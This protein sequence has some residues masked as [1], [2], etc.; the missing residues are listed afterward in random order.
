[1]KTPFSIVVAVDA[2]FGIGRGGLLPWH[3]PG[4]MKHFKEV[5]LEGSSEAHRNVVIMGRKTWDSIPDKFRPLPGRRNIVLTR[6][7]TPT[8]PSGVERAFDFEDALLKAAQSV[9]SKIFVIGGGEIFKIAI[10]HPSCQRLFLTHIE[11][12]FDCDRFFPSLPSSFKP[13][14]KSPLLQDGKTKYFFCTYER[15]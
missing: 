1:M 15:C 6:D 14:F 13:I 4:D 9:P 5:T 12:T 2:N 10:G 8:F 3:L 11:T 7:I